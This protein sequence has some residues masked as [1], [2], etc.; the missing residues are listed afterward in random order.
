M[1]LNIAVCI[2]IWLLLISVIN[3]QNVKDNICTDILLFV[4]Y[5]P[6]CNIL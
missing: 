2:Y 4:V 5:Y 3:S 1:H 6:V